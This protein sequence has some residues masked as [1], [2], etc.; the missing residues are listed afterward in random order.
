MDSVKSAGFVDSKK[1][2][3]A[4]KHNVDWDSESDDPQEE[5]KRLTKYQVTAILGE[6]ALLPS[7]VTVWRLLRWQL[8]VTAISGLAWSAK[9]KA[10]SLDSSAISAL[11]GGGC[12]FLPGALFAVRAKIIANKAGGAGATIFALVTGEL[13]KI[14]ATVALFVLAVIFYPG[15]EWL[16][17]LVT[18]ILAIK[19][20]LL[21]WIVKW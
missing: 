14:I 5:V 15:L 11:I 13:L 6:K 4:V 20:Y 10:F 3:I 19:C 1:H 7:R 17:L 12:A 16:P 8:I 2:T 9:G 21:A 18:Y